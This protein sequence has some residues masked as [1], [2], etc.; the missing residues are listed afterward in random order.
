MQLAGRVHKRGTL[1]QQR[2]RKYRAGREERTRH[3]GPAEAL[4][5][6]FMRPQPSNEPFLSLRTLPRCGKQQEALPS[7]KGVHAMMWGKDGGRDLTI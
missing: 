7:W 5:P 1:L 3:L 4:L 6:E 2:E